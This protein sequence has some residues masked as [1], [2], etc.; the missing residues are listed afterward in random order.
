MD[1]KIDFVIL[2]VDGNDKKWQKEKNIYKPKLQNDENNNT[3][4]FRDWDN[5]VY[6][7]RMVEENASWVNKIYFITWGHVPIWLNTKNEKL[8]I[9]NHKDYIP[10]E[11]LPTYNSNTIELNLFRIKELS[12]NFVLFNDDMF[13]IRKTKPRD[14]FR[15]GVPLECYSE[16]P[17]KSIKPNDTYDHTLLNNIAIINKY[18][19]KKEVYKKNFFKYFNYRYGIKDNLKTLSLLQY[20]TFSMI[21]NKHVPVALKKEVLKEL[22]HKEYDSFNNSSLNRFR[23]LSDISQYLIRYYQLA[24]GNFI[25]RTSKFGTYI[26]LEN[27]NTKN[28]KKIERKKYKLACFNDTPKVTDFENSK[29]TLNEYFEKKYNKKSSFEK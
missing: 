18:F 10:S 20:S 23:D 15:N 26:A 8:V 25:P 16:I 22:W 5:L 11:Y 19:N 29:R 21:D 7:F 17:H 24:S 6:W 14:F 13:I 28:I 4:R 9:V 1:Q 2:W 12:D 3:I 27:D